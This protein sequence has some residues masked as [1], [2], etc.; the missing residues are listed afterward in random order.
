MATDPNYLAVSLGLDLSDDFDRIL[1]RRQGDPDRK[2]LNVTEGLHALFPQHPAY[3][4]DWLVAG[5]GCR[6]T[7]SGVLRVDE[8]KRTFYIDLEFVYCGEKPSQ[9]FMADAVCKAMGCARDHW[10]FLGYP[11]RVDS[12]MDVDE[13]ELPD[14]RW[15]DAHA[16]YCHQTEEGACLGRD[17][18]TGSALPPCY[19]RVLKAEIGGHFGSSYS[20]ELNFD[21]VC[22]EWTGEHYENRRTELLTPSEE[23]WIQ[24]RADLDAASVW[25]WR[26]R[27]CAPNVSDGDSWAF[28]IKYDD[29]AVRCEGSSWYP[30]ETG[31]GSSKSTPSFKAMLEAVSALIGGREFE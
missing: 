28:E 13:S 15:G 4:I 6:R 19:P 2:R 18:P 9:E 17:T 27:Y 26:K 21:T 20:L 30:T 16:S 23:R 31:A 25:R 5:M 10:T 11:C 8:A 7:Y 12:V 1:K 3:E 22:Y 14:R 24:F 29:A